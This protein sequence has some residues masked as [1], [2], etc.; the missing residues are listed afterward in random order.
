MSDGAP[1]FDDARIAAF[2]RKHHIRKLALFGSRLKGTARPDSDLDLLVEFEA[3]HVPG[4]LRLSGMQNELSDMVGLPV[5]LRLY[6]ELSRYFRD[7]VA[8]QARPV[9]AT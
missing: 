6:E 4:Y 9:Y 1:H 5:D 2:C 3:G 8:A 7:E